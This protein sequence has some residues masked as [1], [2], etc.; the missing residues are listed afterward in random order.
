MVMASLWPVL[1][2]YA[3]RNRSGLPPKRSCLRAQRAMGQGQD[4]AARRNQDALKVDPLS[5]GP[6]A[7][8]SREGAP[9]DAEP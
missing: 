1:E 8:E 7:C 6:I 5:V 2:L 9:S 3:A 4:E